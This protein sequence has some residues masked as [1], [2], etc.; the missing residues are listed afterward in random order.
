MNRS[1]RR[2]VFYLIVAGIV[3]FLIW[4]G[5]RNR[6]SPVL[7]RLMMRKLAST[8]VMPFFS[9]DS[10]ALAFI[11]VRA[12]K[13][14]DQLKKYAE[15]WIFDTRGRALGKTSDIILEEYQE[16]LITKFEYD[17]KTLL[18]QKR[19]YQ[20]GRCADFKCNLDD[21]QH[22][23]LKASGQVVLDISDGNKLVLKRSEDGRGNILGLLRRGSSLEIIKRADPSCESIINPQANPSGEAI[24]FQVHSGSGGIYHD[25]LWY[26]S[27]NSRRLALLAG[28]SFNVLLSPD[29]KRVAYLIPLS[30]N[31]RM[32][33]S[34]QRWGLIIRAIGEE[35]SDATILESFSEDVEL[36]SW[37]PDG[38]DILWKKGPTLNLHRVEQGE[39]QVLLDSK[40]DGWWGF[41][42]S[43]YYVSWSP[44]SRKIA[45]TTFLVSQDGRSLLERVMLIDEASLSK[46]VLHSEVLTR[47]QSDSIYAFSFHPH[48]AWSASGEYL[49]FE[50]KNSSTP[51]S[52]EIFLFDVKRENMKNLSKGFLGIFYI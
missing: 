1:V 49:A 48:I 42:P 31:A 6:T 28:D 20:N 13:V 5:F 32:M 51:A 37:S 2:L 25:Q 16:L 43:P 22:S 29:D 52:A 26:Y 36:Y 35:T 17:H 47:T 38:R 44:D 12:E 11:K 15:I 10:K 18:F 50:G 21:G 45:V 23:E 39:T 30:R 24:L 34:S 8:Y 3:T 41:P 4:L 14:G 27:V 9:R 40:G 19:N 46:A 33:K 7:P